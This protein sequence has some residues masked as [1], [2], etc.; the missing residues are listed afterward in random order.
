M[1]F[2]DSGTFLAWD[3]LRPLKSPICTA[4]G[5]APAAPARCGGCKFAI[6]C[7]L[8]CQRSCAAMHAEGCKAGYA[9]YIRRLEQHTRTLSKLQH[10]GAEH[11]RV[12]AAYEDALAAAKGMGDGEGQRHLHSVMAF[13]LEAHGQTEAAARHQAA[14]ARIEEVIGKQTGARAIFDKVDR[15]KLDPL[16]RNAQHGP[17]RTSWCEWEQTAGEVTV[18]VALPPGTRKQ[19]LAVGFKPRHLTVSLVGGIVLADGELC[20]AVKPDDC[21]WSIS[22][23][24]QLTITLEKAKP[25]VWAGVLRAD[26][27]E[28]QAEGS[29]SIAPPEPP[30]ADAAARVFGQHRSAEPDMGVGPPP[31]AEP[32]PQGPHPVAGLDMN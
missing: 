3:P 18:T 6:F 11:G 12:L 25:S 27:R 1:S 26:M 29:T 16:G 9:D 7:G 15:T 2:T 10:E 19:Q 31:P 5:A 28:G 13:R 30:D 4:C 21:T 23:G 32:P 8:E 14:A 22:D 20:D 17:G 24:R